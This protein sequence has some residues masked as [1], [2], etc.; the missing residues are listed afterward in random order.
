MAVLFYQKVN[1]MDKSSEEIIEHVIKSESCEM[2]G[3]QF[4]FDP[5][6]DQVKCSFCGNIK[7]IAKT[8]DHVEK[9][10]ILDM[11]DYS[12]D[13]DVKEQIITCQSCGGKIIAG[14]NDMTKDCI[15]CGSNHVIHNEKG[16]LGLRPKAMIP[17]KLNR[18]HAM[19]VFKNWLSNEKK[20][21][22]AH[23][24]K[25]IIK[26]NRF[27]ELKGIY[28]PFWSF[29]FTSQV[30]WHQTNENYNENQF[31]LMGGE[32]TRTS[33]FSNDHLNQLQL[34]VKS[35]LAAS[36]TW[37]DSYE[38]EDLVDYKPE[39]LQGFY[40]EK[41]NVKPEDAFS[42]ALASVNSQYEALLI[43]MT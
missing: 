39:Y 6:I 31:N 20:L 8:K 40:A 2:C 4:V 17:F 28:M 5:V 1:T 27:Q 26:E 38:L 29:D 30:I 32:E 11:S 24:P 35:K 14:V 9:A 34:G 13:W 41:Y 22:N 23:V 16:D 10:S 18:D 33:S 21:K 25:S 42:D 37:I 3:G 15:F 12:Y 19:A 43:L 36:L 7:P